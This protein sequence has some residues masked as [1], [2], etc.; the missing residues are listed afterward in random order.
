MGEKEEGERETA[1]GSMSVGHGACVVK[2]GRKSEGSRGSTTG[3]PLHRKSISRYRRYQPDTETR[4]TMKEGQSR[5]PHRIE[6][7]CRPETDK[8]YLGDV[9]PSATA[10]ET[11]GRERQRKRETNGKK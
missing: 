10:R 5:P 11:D 9:C 6:S 1:A 2:L 3:R 8:Q 4:C 7:V